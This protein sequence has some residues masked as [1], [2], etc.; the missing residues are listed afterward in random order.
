M[1]LKKK[2]LPF[3]CPHA[4]ISCTKLNTATNTLHTSCSECENYNNGILLTG[5][6]IEIK[7]PKWITKWFK[8]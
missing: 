7:L 3:Q 8:K 6:L 2:K 4:N 5:G 1:K